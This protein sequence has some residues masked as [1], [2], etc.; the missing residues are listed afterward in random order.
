MDL[1]K[2]LPQTFD[3]SLNEITK[4]EGSAALEV[5]V[6][7]GRVEHVHFKTTHC[8]RFFT[9]AMRGKPIMALPQLL[10]RICGTCSNAHL[11]ASVEA[12][13]HALGITPTRQTMLLRMLTMYG[14][15]IRD[16]GLH[17][18]I[19]ALPDV[20]QKDS[21]LDFDERDPKEREFLEDAF[22][23]KAA[24][25]YLSTIIAGRSVHAIYPTIG[26]FTHFPEKEETKKAV[27]RLK[28]VR[29]SALRLID[30]WREC[31]F[32]FKRDTTYMGLVTDHFGFLEGRVCS[33]RGECIPEEHIGEHLEHTVL[34]YSQASAY[35]HEG[36]SYM[37]GALA[38]LNLA[39]DRLHSETKKSAKNALALFPSNDVFH[40]NLAQAIEI[41]HSIDHSIEILTT[42]KFSKEPVIKKSPRGGTGIGVVEAPRG[43]LYYKVIVGGDGK[44][45]GGD[46]VVPT[47]QN[48][49]KM[50]EDIYPLVENLLPNTSKEEIAFEI[51]KLIRAYD[52]CMSCA[53]HFLKVHWIES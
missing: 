29:E 33:S 41:L 9:Q 48:Q 19:F 6:K 32:H 8:K 28:A 36:E 24:G 10:E 17:L 21:I 23:V 38:R 50:E 16:H 25:N 2:K 7:N 40:N 15:M 5:R 13:E 42:N 31:P 30:L 46:S 1:I 52:P 3:L 37:V 11:M 20:F 12:C 53:A 51:E 39:K 34:P 22:A 18:Y 35:K 45:I 26:G 14:L 4:I 27:F 49:I 44:V 47:G 43:T